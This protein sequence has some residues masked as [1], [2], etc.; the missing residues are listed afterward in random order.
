MTAIAHR[1]VR[2]AR[3]QAAGVI[4]VIIAPPPPLPVSR[5]GPFGPAL[6]SSLAGPKGP[7]PTGSVSWLEAIADVAD[8]LH[9]RRLA[10]IAFDLG[11]QRRHAAIDA[12]RRDDD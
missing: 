9:V 8:R 3:R 1:P 4:V 7:A 12:A 11:A 6:N 5:A 2:T 10:G